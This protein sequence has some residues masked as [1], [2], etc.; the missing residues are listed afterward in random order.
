MRRIS[1]RRAPL[2]R[3]S[4]GTYLW[5]G[6]T[7]LLAVSWLS[8][9]LPRDDRQALSR[10]PFARAQYMEG[11][12]QYNY[13]VNLGKEK[14]AGQIQYHPDLIDVF[15]PELNM[16]PADD[17]RGEKPAVTSLVFGAG[18]DYEVNVIFDPC[19]GHPPDC[20]HGLYGTPEYLLLENTTSQSILD[21]F[22]APFGDQRSR[23]QDRLLTVDEICEG[24]EKP[25]RVEDSCLGC[26]DPP[27]AGY[28]P[29]S[30]VL[31]LEACPD[32]VKKHCAINTGIYTSNIVDVDLIDTDT[33]PELP[34]DMY[35][36]QLGGQSRDF[37]ILCRVMST[38]C[39]YNRNRICKTSALG[40]PIGCR[41][42]SK[43]PEM[44]DPP[45]D[46]WI[47]RTRAQCE[48]SDECPGAD[49]FCIDDAFSPTDEA[50]NADRNN[51]LGC[52]QQS[53]ENC[54]GMML[55]DEDGEETG[56]YAGLNPPCITTCR[57]IDIWRRDCV[58]RRVSFVQEPVR[59]RCWDYNDTVPADQDCYK[60]DGTL[61]RYCVQMAFSMNAMVHQ[62]SGFQGQGTYSEDP[63]CGTFIEV[64]LPSTCG[65]FV[66][67]RVRA[68]VSSAFRLALDERS[69][70]SRL[71]R[72]HCTHTSP[73][74]EH[75]AHTPSFSSFCGQTSLPVTPTAHCISDTVTR[76]SWRC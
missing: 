28:E 44:T 48:S 61:K 14:L 8:P 19:R 51:G 27:Y 47:K 40:E 67:A 71:S 37:Q 70:A 42:C 53:T 23:L 22:G 16:I 11:T 10:L 59:A 49:N 65:L 46:G 12:S 52:V 57:K 21:R 3:G 66:C 2:L 75:N 58:R 4:I 55:L 35:T 50:T 13:F 36:N 32:D 69:L 30:T 33:T 68:C 72:T 43:S 20:C 45:S 41:Y 38:R 5:S 31:P 9:L 62:C 56:E 74:H 25:F 6:L 1:P 24:R 73:T 54:K 34:T 15:F 76:K 26:L 39:R 18:Q 29:G 64:H 63:H 60:P 17:Y 7:L